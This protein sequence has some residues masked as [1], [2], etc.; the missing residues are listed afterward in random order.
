L[1]SLRFVSG[2]S[3]GDVVPLEVGR[4]L[5]IGRQADADLVVGDELVS[6]Q[7]ARLDFDGDELVIEDL[8]STNGTYLNGARVVTRA[9]VSEDDRIL[10][11]GTIIKVMARDV[12][13]VL[14]G[15]TATAPMLP[16]VETTPPP[17]A[18]EARRTSG[19][20]GRLE[21][22]PL[23]DLLQLFGTSRKSG[24]L[25]LQH[26]GHTAELRLDKGRVVSCVLDGRGDLPGDKTF[27]RLVD[28]TT[29]SFELGP[30]PA[31][32][33]P[34]AQGL[35]QPME[36]LLMEGMRQHD[37]LKRLRASLPPLL[38]PGGAP[39]GD[40]DADDRALLVLAAT[41]GRLEAV[42][43]AMPLPDLAVAERLAALLQRGL[44]VRR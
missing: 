32:A 36:A 2:P 3:Q 31:S 5:V 28:W 41:E 12:R 16:R 1:F 20:Q 22:V 26:E 18:G 11:G 25:V 7:H 33:A 21:E 29:G 6:R 9:I 44:L 30:A 10:L 38:A 4:A 39:G 34:V 43:D 37:E 8:G 24:V 19:M 27:Y 13:A 35:G 23:P 14:A 15:A 42:L 40:V 17:V